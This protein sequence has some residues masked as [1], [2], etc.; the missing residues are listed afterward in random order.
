MT[1]YQINSQQYSIH[2]GYDR[3]LRTFFATVEDL[4][5]SDEENYLL[6]WI[7]TSYDEIRSIAQLQNQ[8]ADYCSLPDNIIIKLEQDK[9]EPFEPSYVQSLA[10]YLFTKATTQ[11]QADL[12]AES[13]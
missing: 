13:D 2:V 7:G 9:S 5:L 3:P 10:E 1:R 8:I 12:K 6:L 11:T 4:N